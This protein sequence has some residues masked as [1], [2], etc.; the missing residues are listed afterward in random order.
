MSK[1]SIID[2]KTIKQFRKAIHYTLN[3]LKTFKE[4][5]FK[6]SNII[7]TQD[8]LGNLSRNDTEYQF[9]SLTKQLTP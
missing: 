7:L 5:G 3:E 8:T 9:Y 2:E 4:I 1:T 6:R